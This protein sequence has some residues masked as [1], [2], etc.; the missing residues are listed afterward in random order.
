MA[1]T[2]SVLNGWIEKGYC[3]SYAVSIRHHDKRERLFS[4]G[5]DGDTYFDMASAGKVLVTSTLVLHAVDEGKLKLTDTIGKFYPNAPADKQNITVE[6]MLTHTSGILRY[7]LSYSDAQ[8][9]HDALAE[10]ILNT[11]LG[12]APGSTYTYSCNGFIL[13]GFIVEKIYGKTLNQVH[14][15]K[16]RIPL[17][18]T[19]AAFSLPEGE[20]NR[21]IS[22]RRDADGK[23]PGDD[24]NL[25]EIRECVGSGG[26]FF[27]LFD[28]EKFVDAVVERSPILYSKSLFDLAERD[29][30]P[31]FS[32]GRGL[33]Y[34]YIDRRFVQDESLLS[35][36]SF[37]HIGATGTG[38]FIDRKHDLS[39]IYLTNLR[40]GI[41]LNYH[42][43]YEQYSK[44][45][46]DLRKELFETLPKD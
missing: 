39:I 33:G 38:F 10:F 41:T 24:E 14:A 26:Q 6:Q 20:K 43:D 45:R 16:L 23:F 7:P 25:Y 36:G 42:L 35:T 9:G 8:K 3:D 34:F 40:R 13:L 1:T 46:F 28:V 27:S 19:R 12:F 4:N 17:G 21:V 22:H 30:T 5:V 29:Y 11:P 32:E 2:R 15:E 44:M 31:D 18:M 37:G